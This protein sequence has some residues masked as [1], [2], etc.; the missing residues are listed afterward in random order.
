MCV[1]AAC[2]GSCKGEDRSG[3]QPFAPTV[4]TLDAYAEGDSVRLTGEIVESPNSALRGRGF[5]YGNDTLRVLVVSE[6]TTDLFQA[7]ADSLEA[8]SYYA[9]AFATNGVGTSFG[10][11]LQFTIK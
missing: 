4:R 7:V 3:E 11:T 6:D 10:D 5:I 1:L 2:L 9:H 8:G